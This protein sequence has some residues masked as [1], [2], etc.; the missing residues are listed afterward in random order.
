MQVLDATDLAG[1]GVEEL[2]GDGLRQGVTLAAVLLVAADKVVLLVHN[3]VVQ[4]RNLVGRVLQVS[5]HRDDDIALSLFETTEQGWALAVVAAKL[6]ALHV[7][8]LGGKFGNDF[9]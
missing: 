7:L 8:R 4:F 3:H 2:G 6:D 1:G 9:P 5:I